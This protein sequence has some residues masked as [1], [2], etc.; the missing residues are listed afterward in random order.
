MT[1]K[2]KTVSK[3]VFGGRKRASFSILMHFIYFQYDRL[4]QL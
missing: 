3:P 4:P 2:K 1:K